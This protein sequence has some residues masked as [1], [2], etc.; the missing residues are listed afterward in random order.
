MFKIRGRLRIFFGLCPECNS[1]APEKYDCKVCDNFYGYPGVEEKN[2]WWNNY[3]NKSNMTRLELLNR[4][5]QVI[6]IRVYKY[7]NSGSD[8]IGYGL[9]WNVLPFTGWKNSYKTIL[10]KKVKLFKIT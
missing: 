5:I 4:I 1:D 8:K 6:G 2:K 10:G 7:K 3:K 9:M